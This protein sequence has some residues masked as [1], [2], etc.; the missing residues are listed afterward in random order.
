MPGLTYGACFNYAAP[1]T[2]VTHVSAAAIT[3][4]LS[5]ADAP[6]T[7]YAAPTLVRPLAAA[8]VLCGGRSG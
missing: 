5:A 4:T 6:R 8:S 1:R 2:S 7:R 3:A